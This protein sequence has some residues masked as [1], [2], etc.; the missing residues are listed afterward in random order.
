MYKTYGFA[1]EGKN[2]LN[3]EILTSEVAVHEYTHLWDN[4]TQKTNPELLEKGKNILK[5]TSYWYEVKLDP[6][7]ADIKNNDDL[8]LSEIHSRI[9]GKMADAVLGRITETD[10]KI[11]K[12]KAIDWD[13]KRDWKPQHI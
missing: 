9:C 12:D 8:V 11:T 13:K 2:Y 5:N 6:N 7:Y 3:P 10:G 4:Y 1:Y